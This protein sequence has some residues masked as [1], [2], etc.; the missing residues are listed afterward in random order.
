MRRIVRALQTSRRTPG[1][2]PLTML[3]WWNGVRGCLWFAFKMLYRLRLEGEENVPRTG[4]IIYVANHQAHMDPCIVGILVGDRAFSGMARKTLFTNPILSWM[5]RGIGVIALDQ[6][7]GDTAA[8]KAG[9]AELEAGRCLL[10]FPEGTRT[11]D[12]AVHKFKPGAALLIR[13]SGAP[14]VPVAIEGAYDIWR[15]GTPRPKLTGRL[16]VR[17]APM[18]SAEE[19]L[20]GGVEAGLQRL[21]DQI[22]A[23]RL[24]LRLRLRRESGGR[25]PA[26][27]AGDANP[28]A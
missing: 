7:K 11:R 27:S 23:M 13:R 21:H 4:P 14:V 22:D 1:W 26:P 5:M 19:V 24:E 25:Y 16:A 12:G 2:P 3:F 15:I 18:V 10:I 20:R 9:L 28:A 17:A 8:M 6:S